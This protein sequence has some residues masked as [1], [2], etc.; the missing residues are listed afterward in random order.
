MRLAVEICSDSSPTLP[1]SKK[2]IFVPDICFFLMIF[3]NFATKN[4]YW[5]RNMAH[6]SLLTEEQEKELELIR[7]MTDEEA[8]EWAKQFPPAPEGKTAFDYAQYVDMTHEEFLEAYDLED[9]TDEIMRYV[10]PNDEE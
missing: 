9:M 7:S 3:I 1:Q 10:T 2:I 5:N 8:N 6:K 4:I